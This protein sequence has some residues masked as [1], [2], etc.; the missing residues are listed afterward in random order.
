[1]KSKGK[2]GRAAA[3]FGGSD[4]KGSRQ[5]PM[6]AASSVTG[7]DPLA[8]SV[9]QYGKGASYLPSPAPPDPAMAPNAQGLTIDHPGMNQQIRDSGGGIRDRPRKGGITDGAPQ[10]QVPLGD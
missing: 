4:P 8:A 9:G 1:M 6:H 7:G 10:P 3:L 2:I 5:A